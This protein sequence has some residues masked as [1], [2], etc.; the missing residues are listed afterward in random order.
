MKCK[1]CDR[2]IYYQES[3]WFFI[4]D[5]VVVYMMYHLE[6]YG[7]VFLIAVCNIGVGWIYN[8]QRTKKFAKR[9]KNE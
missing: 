3:S 1:E 9:G 8:S 6:F 7:I 2:K 5:V 4:I